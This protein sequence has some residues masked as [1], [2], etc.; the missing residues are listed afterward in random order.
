MSSTSP[1]TVRVCVA[2]AEPTWLDLQ[3]GVEKTIK[4]ATE[5][6][7]NGA[8]LIAFPELWLT[9]YPCWIWSRPVD[10]D[11]G[12]KYIK[13]SI[14]DGSPELQAFQTCARENSIAI[15]LGCSENDNNS[16][17]ISQ[18]L[19]DQNGKIAIH[20]RKIKPTHMERT[21]FGDGSER[22]L[23][24]VAELPF[25]RVGGLSCWEHVQPLLKYHSITQRP[26]IHVAGWPVLHEFGGEGL[27]SMS[28]DGCENL[29]RT[30]AVESGAFV[31]HATTVISEKGIELLRTAGAP[32]MST[33]GGGY[34]AVYGPDGRRLTEPLPEKEEG[35]VYADLNL[36]MILNSRMFLD[37]V[38]H[39]S[40]PDILWLGV[41]SL[42][43]EVLRGN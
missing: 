21:I 31:L 5:A 9:G 2:Q 42:A 24:I 26:E 10:P 12:L 1:R 41:D 16:L 28:S 3:A 17:Y 34:S 37:S 19:I 20:R 11:L 18:F 6:A 25:A 23:E 39:Y 33:P 22:S 4:L 29:S 15:S 38:G 14:R 43:K 32:L 8:Q 27:W 30:Y 40:R 13:N 35:L 7:Q 36:D